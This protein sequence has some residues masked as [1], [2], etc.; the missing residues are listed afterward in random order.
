LVATGQYGYD[1]GQLTSLGYTQGSTTLDG[2]TWSYDA[3]G[4]VTQ[5]TN[6]IDG[7]ANYLYDPTGQLTGVTYSGPQANEGYQYDSNGNRTSG[8]TGVAPVVVGA[9]NHVTCDGTYTYCYDADGNETARW[10]ASASGETQPGPGDTDITT[11]AWDYRNRLTTVT[12][13][14]SY[15]A[16][17]SNTPDKTVAYSYDPLNRLVGE[18]VTLADQ[19]WITTVFVYDGSQVALQFDSSGAT[20]SASALTAA[21]LSHRYLWGPAVDQLLADEQVTTPS[22]A[23]EVVWPLA[24]NQG[25]V[26]DLA[27]YDAATGT[28]TIINHRVYDAFGNLTSQTNAAVDC[29]FGYAGQMFDQNTGLVYSRARWYDPATGRFLSQDR[30]DCVPFPK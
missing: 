6:A 19:S 23:G 9:N 27:V 8:G 25:T 2:Y 30:N 24:D 18:T 28:T 16:F 29:L 12:H 14:A 13:Y 15:A 4:R 5:M 20:G 3:A 17:S 21:D 7:T 1:A 22:Q 11:Y 10:I 26:R